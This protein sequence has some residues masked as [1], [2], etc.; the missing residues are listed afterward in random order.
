M[1]ILMSRDSADRLHWCA[2][3]E[4]TDDETGDQ[5]GTVVAI[6]DER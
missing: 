4:S 6:L 2:L 3:F 5:R 1:R